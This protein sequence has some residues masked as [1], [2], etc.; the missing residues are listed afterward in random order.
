MV[1]FGSQRVNR[2]VKRNRTSPNDQTTITFK[3]F[4]S[5]NKGLEISFSSSTGSRSVS[6]NGP[7]KMSCLYDN[8]I[9]SIEQTSF[10]FFATTTVH[11]IKYSRDGYKS[12]PSSKPTITSHLNFHRITKSLQKF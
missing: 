7:P 5:K 11:A 2:E 10:A 6:I 8:Y 1:T 9:I 12:F 4:P 3:V